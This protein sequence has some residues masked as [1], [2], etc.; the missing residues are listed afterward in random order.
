MVRE[1]KIASAIVILCG[2]LFIGFFL[3]VFMITHAEINQRHRDCTMLHTNYRDVY[4]NGERIRLSYEVP[5]STWL[6]KDG[7]Q[8]VFAD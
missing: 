6:C 8:Y 1:L 4:R 3:S 2:V 5:K 7:K